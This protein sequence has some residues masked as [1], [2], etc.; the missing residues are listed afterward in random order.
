MP[1][2][3]KKVTPVAL[4]LFWEIR[5]H[6]DLKPVIAYAF[7]EGYVAKREAAYEPLIAA[8]QWLACQVQAMDEGRPFAMMNGEVN[9]LY[10]ALRQYDANALDKL[11]L[12]HPDHGMVYFKQQ[13]LSGAESARADYDGIVDYTLLKL[14]EAFGS[15]LAPALLQW[16][17]KRDKGELRACCLS[18]IHAD[19]RTVAIRKFG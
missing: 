9:E 15:E 11:A 10:N 8:L 6:F 14:E 3:S 13:M 5:S 2:V 19:R 18:T 7:K 17:S 1:P 12:S 16:I 4:E